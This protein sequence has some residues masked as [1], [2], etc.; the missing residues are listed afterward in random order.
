MWLTECDRRGAPTLELP[1]DEIDS[2]PPPTGWCW[3]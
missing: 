2:G 1:D 3:I